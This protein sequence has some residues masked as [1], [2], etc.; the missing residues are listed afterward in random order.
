YAAR[1]LGMQPTG[2][3]GGVRNLVISNSGETQQ[4]LLK[5]MDRG[6]LVTEAMGPGVNLVTG[7]YSRGAA[8]FWVD[9][10]EI[11]YPVEGFTLAS[12]LGDMFRQLAGAATDVD[13]RGNIR[14][15]SL[16][17]EQM[18]IAGR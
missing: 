9:H 12:D 17:I 18:N 6:V 1:R 15:G 11:Q 16:L 14:V 3:G 4:Q 8:G 7:D 5:K 2:N 13:D 10:G